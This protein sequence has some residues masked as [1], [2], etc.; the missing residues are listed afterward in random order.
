M[1]FIEFFFWWI[2]LVSRLFSKPSYLFTF[3]SIKVLYCHSIVV[4]RVVRYAP[5]G[6][7]L[8]PNSYEIS[9]SMIVW[10]QKVYPFSRGCKFFNIA[11]NFLLSCKAQNSPFLEKHLTTLISRISYNYDCQW[12]SIKQAT[13]VTSLEKSR[14][15]YF[16]DSTC[17]GISEKVFFLI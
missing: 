12:L 1:L 4:F 9:F 8:L 10:E 16:V 5:I 3:N 17:Q 7:K 14:A 2:Q 15:K 13:S 11:T 6:R